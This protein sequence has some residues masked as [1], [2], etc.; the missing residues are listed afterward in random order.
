MLILKTL[1]LQ[2]GYMP[3]V[4]AGARYH[5]NALGVILLD[6]ICFCCDP[7]FGHVVL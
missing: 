1:Y 4:A 7:T 2:T 3:I 6:G 5:R